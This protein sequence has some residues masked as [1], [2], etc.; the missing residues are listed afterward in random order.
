[1]IWVRV[2]LIGRTNVACLGEGEWR[3]WITPPKGRLSRIA[4]KC[5]HESRRENKNTKKINGFLLLVG[6]LARTGTWTSGPTDTRRPGQRNQDPAS[7]CVTPLRI[8]SSLHDG[9][10]EWSGITQR[11]AEITRFKKVSKFTIKHFCALIVKSK[12]NRQCD[13][14]RWYALSSS[15][16]KLVS[17]CNDQRFSQA[18]GID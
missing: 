5:R 18:P 11:P 3:I 12:K 7:N 17:T 15:G 14:K 10:P 9:K 16:Y 2:Y 6:H 4:K 1:M 8:P 13:Q